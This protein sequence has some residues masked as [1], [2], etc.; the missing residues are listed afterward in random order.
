MLHSNKCVHGDIQGT[1]SQA[2]LGLGYWANIICVLHALQSLKR[3]RLE[4]KGF[5]ARNRALYG[6]NSRRFCRG[7]WLAT[8][9]CNKDH[10][11]VARCTA[12]LAEPSGRLKKPILLCFSGSRGATIYGPCFVAKFLSASITRCRLYHCPVCTCNSI[13]IWFAA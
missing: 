10:A 8:F 7:C 12:G 11:I 1:S 3:Y 4:C 9:F 2:A 13:C 6:F 5:A